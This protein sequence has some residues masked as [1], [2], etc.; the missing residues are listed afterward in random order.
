[1]N[2]SELLQK[3]KEMGIKGVSSKTK[4]EI[5]LIIKEQEQKKENTQINFNIIENKLTDL[6]K[7]LIIKTPKDNQ[8]VVNNQVI[9]DDQVA[10]WAKDRYSVPVTNAHIKEFAIWAKDKYNINVYYYRLLCI[11]I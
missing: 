3:C 1:M 4:S 6:L 5:L 7:E 11:I 2:K 10:L 8:D 9:A